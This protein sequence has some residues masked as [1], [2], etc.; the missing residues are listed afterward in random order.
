MGPRHPRESACD[1]AILRWQRRRE[2]AQTGLTHQRRPPTREAAPGPVRVGAP[3]GAL[4]TAGT[5]D[6]TQH[7]VWPAG[8]PQG[9][10]TAAARLHTVS[11]IGGL[12]RGWLGQGHLNAAILRAP[13]GGGVRG[14][15]LRRAQSPRRDQV[16]LHAL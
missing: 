16:R 3:V 4:R 1:Y 13:L 9:T 5:R 11:K 7:H 12:A 14:E 15:G 8:M 2:Q 6:Q 10:V